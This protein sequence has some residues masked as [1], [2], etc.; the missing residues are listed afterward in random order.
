MKDYWNNIYKNLTNNKPTYDLW[1]NKYK[2]I[3]DKNKETTILDLGCGSGSDTL[4]LI[5][6]NYKVLS[7]DYCEEA[8]NIVKKHIPNSKT[9]QLDLTEKLPF[10]D[11]SI[12]IIIADLSLHYFNDVTTKSIINE[13]KRI[14]KASGYLIGRV[15][16]VNDINYGALSGKEI[17]KHFYLTES[18]YKRFFN[19]EDI[20]YYFKDFEINQCT[21][22][23]ITRYGSEK[24]A[25][26]FVVY[27]V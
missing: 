22:E 1:L 8:L 9:I 17:E 26:E 14:L 3:L 18:G 12:S 20:E 19:K 13:I 15:N 16:S 24:I 6:R 21:E 10:K 23:S 7:Y 2:S 27:R 4:Y 11:E 5:E 25:W